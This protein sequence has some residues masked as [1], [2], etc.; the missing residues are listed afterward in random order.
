MITHL[1]G[2]VEKIT[3]TSVVLD[4]NGVGYSLLCSTKTME[5]VRAHSDIVRMY[6]V[7][8]IREDSWILYGFH[9]EQERL[10]F[11]QLTSVQ[12]VGGKVAIAILSVLSDDEMYHA[13]L[14]GDTNIFTRADG[15]GAKLATRIVS[16]LKE[17]IIGKMEVNFTMQAAASAQ[18]G[19]TND[20]LSALSNLG[21]QKADIL[22][23]LSTMQI[24]TTVEFDVL[25]K[26]VLS[27]LSVGIYN[28]K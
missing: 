12:G 9:T 18:S 3:D 20:V 6:T 11:N 24:E 13:F 19:V 16:E 26:R 21:Y 5:N 2:I 28:E 10:W 22:R 1:N 15:V 27:K 4:V 14:T 8:N 17:K 7:L 23:V 25:L